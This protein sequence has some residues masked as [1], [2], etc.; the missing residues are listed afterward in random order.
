MGG[1]LATENN[2][3]DRPRVGWRVADEVHQCFKWR[4]GEMWKSN[5]DSALL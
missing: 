3:G 4:E 5:I 1:E 2:A